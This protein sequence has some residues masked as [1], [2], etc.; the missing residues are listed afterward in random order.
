MTDLMSRRPTAFGRFLCALDFHLGPR[1]E[2]A[3]VA[4]TKVEE[5]APLAEEV[6]GRWLPNLVAA[7]MVGGHPEGAAAGPPPLG[8]AAVAGQ[9]PAAGLRDHAC[10]L[11][12]S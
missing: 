11:P 8:R 6:F 10:P 5:T 12:G 2:I 9:A 3:L 1:V 7:G 4:P